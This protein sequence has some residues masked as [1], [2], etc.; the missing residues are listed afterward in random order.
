MERRNN[1]IC[2]TKTLRNKEEK[3]DS[4]LKIPGCRR[5]L[6]WLFRADVLEPV[7]AEDLEVEQVDGAVEF[8]VT[9]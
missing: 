1:R 9:L 4:G 5:G 2:T 6:V 8:Q 3:V 7:T